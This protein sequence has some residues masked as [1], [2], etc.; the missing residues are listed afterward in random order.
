MNKVKFPSFDLSGPPC[1]NSGCVGILTNCLEF[2]T[3]IWFTR[4]SICKIESP[5]KNERIIKNIIE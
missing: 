5:T 1:K 2:K 3:H 4:C